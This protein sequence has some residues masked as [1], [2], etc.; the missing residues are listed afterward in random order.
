MDHSTVKLSEERNVLVLEPYYL[1]LQEDFVAAGFPLA[2]RTTFYVAPWIHDS[3]RHF[4]ACR[5]DG[6]S[7]VVAPE[8]VELPEQTVCGIVAHEL[9]HAV[10]F[11]Y[12]G[13]FALGQGGSAL[14]RGPGDLGEEQWAR[15]MLDWGA[16]DDDQVEMTADAIAELGT[17]RR[18]GYL[19]PCQLQS[20]DGGRARPQ[21][22][23]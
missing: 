14:R 16:R 19:G 5:E 1:A 12:P 21:G 9:G 23:R 22:L 18:I 2:K 13:Q 3:P 10:D 4:A 20:F 17:G 7:I 11:L 8:L 15:W 6:L